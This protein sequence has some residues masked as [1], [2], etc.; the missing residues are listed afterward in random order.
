VHKREVQKYLKAKATL[1]KGLIHAA[2]D[3]FIEAEAYRLAAS[4]SFYTISSIFPLL[5]VAL[6]IGEMVLGDSREL[7]NSLI[8]ALNATDSAAVRAL[9][10]DTLRGIRDNKDPNHWGIVIGLFGAAFGASGIFLELDTSMGK[11]FRIPSKKTSIWEDIRHALADRAAALLLVA[12]TSLVLL[13]S[14]LVLSAVEVVA[15]HMPSVSRVAPGML[16]RFSAGA[17]TVLAIAL[18]YRVVPDR[19][20]RF[21]AAVLGALVAAA[22]F[23]VVRW[24]LTWA[25]AHLTSY[26]AYGVVG[27]LLLLV[28]WFYVASCILLGGAALTAVRD[29]QLAPKVDR[30]PA[31]KHGTPHREGAAEPPPPDR[32]AEPTRDGTPTA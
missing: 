22:A 19:P 4:L 5:L 21:S 11:L 26:A 1:A 31:S 16:P 12:A 29:E 20:V 27:S 24:P 10:E 7:Q 14:S 9:L 30:G 28:T 8:R 13:S 6:S 25:V 18:C 23:Y 3:R 15:A 32:A 2:A 17:T